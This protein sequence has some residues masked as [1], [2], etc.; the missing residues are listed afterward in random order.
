MKF[1]LIPTFLST[2]QFHSYQDAKTSH[3]PCSACFS[4]FSGSTSLGRLISGAHTHVT[5]SVNLLLQEV[6]QLG[7]H[8]KNHLAL[9]GHL[10]W[11]TS[12]LRGFKETTKEH[13][14]SSRIKYGWKAK[15]AH[16]GS[17][18]FIDPQI[19]SDRNHYVSSEM[20]EKDEAKKKQRNRL[21][22]KP[23]PKTYE[24]T[25]NKWASNSAETHSA[26]VRTLKTR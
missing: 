2:T 25:T 11:H 10:P 4:C 13:I 15:R 26:C 5:P 17:H 22:N 6:P 21:W 16:R 23:P 1:P 19:N 24:V 14:L 20:F 8:L 12:F 7:T 18:K 3:P 9:L